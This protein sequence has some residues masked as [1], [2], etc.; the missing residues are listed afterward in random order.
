M[1]QCTHNIRFANINTQSNNIQFKTALLYVI[2][3]EI[4]HTF[5]NWPWMTESGAEGNGTNIDAGQ[6]KITSNRAHIPLDK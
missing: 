2:K 1:Q 5:T 4:L 3:I 6:I